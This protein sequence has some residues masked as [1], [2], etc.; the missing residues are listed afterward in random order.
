MLRVT[1]L[2]NDPPYSNNG[3]VRYSIPPGSGTDGKFEIDS[4]TGVITVADR[5]TFDYSVKNQYIFPV[6]TLY[7]DI[8]CWGV[9]LDIM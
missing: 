9:S 6:S 7:Y 2:D 8:K 4:V 3:I 1:A 5:T